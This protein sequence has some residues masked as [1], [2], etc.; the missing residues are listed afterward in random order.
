MV[1]KTQD[2]L[3]GVLKSARNKMKLTQEKFAE[4]VE[5]SARYITSIENEKKK[6]AFDKLYTM[7]RALGVNANDIFY[8]ESR[9]ADTPREHL[10]RMLLQCSEREIKAVTALVE[11][12]LSEK[13]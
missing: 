3:G 12:L 7:I 11:S 8:P 2:G 5:V 9:K 1:R 6:P 4:M 13:E 10:S